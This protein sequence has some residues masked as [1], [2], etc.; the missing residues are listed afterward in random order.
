MRD[1]TGRPQRVL[2]LGGTSEIGLATIEALEL[3][4]SATVIL[5]GRDLAALEKV[6]DSLGCQVRTLLFDAS[7]TSSHE[8]SLDAAF[9]D[10]DVDVVLAAFGI[11]GDQQRAED[12]PEHA[13]E[14]FRTNLDG[15]VSVL[16]GA[17]KRLRRQ[18]HGTIV[19]FS[20]IAGVRARRANFVYGAAKAGLDAFAQGL[21]DSLVGS[22]VGVMVVRP[23]FVIGRMTAGMDP[24]PMSSTPQQVG[25]AVA[26]GLREGRAD[27]WV[28]SKLAAVAV[29][30]RH[31]PRAV[32]R[33]MPR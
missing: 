2:L 21:S 28:P 18:G 32:W 13:V 22:G 10:G 5:A 15:Q 1:A 8:A 14:I 17:A 31:L 26:A 30:F 29:V 4:V 33:K 20:S 16:L 24:A 19:V 6:G 11:L 23:G 25:Q 27:I 3:P 7:E 9:A 12:E